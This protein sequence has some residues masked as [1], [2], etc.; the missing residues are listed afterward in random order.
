MIR[1]P[2]ES[3][4]TD[5]PFPYST[6]FRSGSNRSGSGSAAIATSPARSATPMKRRAL[7]STGRPPSICRKHRGRSAGSNMARRAWPAEGSIL[8]ADLDTT[9]PDAHPIVEDEADALL[10]AVRLAHLFQQAADARINV[11]D[12][13]H[14]L[15]ASD[16]KRTT[17]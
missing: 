11:E 12:L 5:T 4:R 16:K 3:T 13:H 2:P 6:L 7:P 14:P 1:R 8:R 9:M 17:T 10:G 15:R